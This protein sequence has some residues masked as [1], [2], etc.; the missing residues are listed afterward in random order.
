MIKFAHFIESV[1]RLESF[2]RLRTS[3][4]LVH[5]LFSSEHA[6]IVDVFMLR[7]LLR[8]FWYMMYFIFISLFFKFAFYKYC[9]LI[10]VVFGN[11][12]GNIRLSGSLSQRSRSLATLNHHTITHNHSVDVFKILKYALV[13]QDGVDISDVAVDFAD[14]MLMITPLNLSQHS[15]F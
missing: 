11:V 10:I 8:L 1:G 4:T 15:F 3:K 13:T 2:H 6:G 14:T 7:S 5:A 12:I 9:N